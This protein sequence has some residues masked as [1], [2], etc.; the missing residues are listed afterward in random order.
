MSIFILLMILLPLTNIESLTTKKC[1]SKV[2]I[3]N[4]YIG[5]TII[6]A[7]IKKSYTY[8]DF[9]NVEITR[10]TTNNFRSINKTN[11]SY[12]FMGKSL[13]CPSVSETNKSKEFIF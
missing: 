1:I 4:N 6:I 11:Y 3:E 10:T 12:L 5:E 9:A 13:T 2:V 8:P 7:T